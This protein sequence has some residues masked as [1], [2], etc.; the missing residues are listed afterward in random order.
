M[1]KKVKVAEFF[2]EVASDEIDG[3]SYPCNHCKVALTHRRSLYFDY[4][5]CLNKKCPWNGLMV[6][7]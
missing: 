6:E 7:V 2:K 5:V 3:Q 1:G 4:Y